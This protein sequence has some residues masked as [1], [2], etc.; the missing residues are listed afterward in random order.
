MPDIKFEQV[1]KIYKDDTLGVDD[2]SLFVESGDFVFLVGRSGAGKSTLLR[3]I[4]VQEE[5]TSGEI[6]IG[7]DNIT[8]VRKRQIPYIRRRIGIMDK[9]LGLLPDRNIRENLEFSMIATQQSRKGMGGRIEELLGAV[10]LRSMQ[11]RYPEELS[12][13]EVA[14][15]LLARALITNPRIIIADEPTANLDSDS[16]WDLMCLLNDISRQGITVIVACHDRDL[17][18]IMNKRVITLS[19]GKI[20]GDHKRGRY[21]NWMI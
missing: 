15:A 19:Q 18:N 20:I 16:S 3:L 9:D 4:T 10:G 14:R 8:T 2:I 17:V 7:D 5:A 11:D 12:G 21:N 13:G 1:T 6:H